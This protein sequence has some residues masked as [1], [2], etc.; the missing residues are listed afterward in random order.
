V[1]EI[2]RIDRIV[3]DGDADQGGDSLFEQLQQFPGGLG[4]QRNHPCDIPA[5]TGQ[6]LDQACLHRV[7]RTARHHNGDRGGCLLGRQRH[8]VTTHCDE[9]DVATDE[10]GRQRWEERDVP[11]RVAVLQADV[12][13]LHVS[14]LTQALVEGFLDRWPI[15]CLRT[16][17]EN[18]DAVNFPGLLRVGNERRRE[19][20]EGEQDRERD[21]LH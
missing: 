18:P 7:D 11:F 10:V 15:E 12:L 6:A 21:H 3:E 20:G 14:Q 2:R 17:G 1:E 16:P 19:D 9:V 4:G 5:G 13:P 8:R